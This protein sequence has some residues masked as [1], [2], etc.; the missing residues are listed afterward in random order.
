M[1]IDEEEMQQLGG[2]ADVS[3]LGRLKAILRAPKLVQSRFVELESNFAKKLS[4]TMSDA[5]SAAKNVTSA[6][7]KWK[8]NSEGVEMKKVK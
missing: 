6:A 2:E 3:L 1:W 7:T 5:A 4:S 8:S